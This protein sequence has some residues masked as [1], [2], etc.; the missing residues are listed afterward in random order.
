MTSPF[1]LALFADAFC[2]GDLPGRGGDAVM[3]ICG[4]TMELVRACLPR[5]PIESA[6]DLGCG[7]AP[8][9]ILLAR[10]AARVVA[11]DISPRALAVSRLNL[12][13]HGVGNVELRLGDLY[14]PVRG[15]RYD[16]IAAHPPFVARP[17]GAAAST[18]IHGGARGDELPLR[19]L[20][21]AAEHL[22]RG[23]RAVVLGD[24]PILEGDSL[25]A[26]VRAAVG[27]GDTDVM[28]L[29]SP[30]KNLDEYCAQLAAVEHAELGDAFRR[31]AIA[32]RD[33]LEAMGLRA[34]ALACVVLGPGRGWTSLV[35][36]RHVHDA[37][38]TDDA[39]A[40]L[41]SARRLAFGP[42]EA[43][44]SA[45]LC[46]PE[47]SRR[48]EQPMPDGAPPSLVVQPPA[49]APEQPAALEAPL[50]A[51]VLRISGTDRVDE[52]GGEE[53]IEAAREALLRGVLVQA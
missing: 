12:A 42:R 20:A 44:A 48:V 52:A 1:H 23:G 18:F 36:V 8:V 6:L 50:A 29:Q 17:A 40:R 46:F 2:F 43:L 33:H 3:P 22:A 30:P 45:R 38:I 5:S 14:E 49:G 51:V 26:R 35:P 7:A 9:A 11:T 25:E 10:A 37:P 27:P 34:L 4:A 24:W 39:I 21:G 16:R 31:A 13:L 47:G 15:E 53:A 32:H 19:V 41:L 28:V